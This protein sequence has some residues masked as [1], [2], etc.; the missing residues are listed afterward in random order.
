MLINNYFD[1]KNLDPNYY[2]IVLEN[3]NFEL[4]FEI[5]IVHFYNLFFENNLDL[6]CFE[7]LIYHI[8]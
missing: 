3:Q 7:L 6:N 8:I 4:L 5:V 1:G 2:N